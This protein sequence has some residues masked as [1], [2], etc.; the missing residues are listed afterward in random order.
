MFMCGAICASKTKILET[1]KPYW[2]LSEPVK[3]IM[4]NQNLSKKAQ[5]LCIA[6]EIEMC[7]VVLRFVKGFI[8]PVPQNESPEKSKSPMLQKL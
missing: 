6:A 7:Q 3:I 4:A 8:C 2:N 5:R 1:Y